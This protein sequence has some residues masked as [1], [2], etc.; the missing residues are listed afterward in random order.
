MLHFLRA[1]AGQTKTSFMALILRGPSKIFRAKEVADIEYHGGEMI[2]RHNHMS[3]VMRKSD[4]S[5]YEYKGADQLRDY[6]AADQR[7]CYR[8]M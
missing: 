7:L 5:I 1:R 3:S 2:G 8:F 4:L 6:R